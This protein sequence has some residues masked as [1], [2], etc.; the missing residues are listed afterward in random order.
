MNWFF[1]PIWYQSNFSF[2]GSNFQ[3]L[4]H[5]FLPFF[6]ASPLFLLLP[7]VSLPFH[8]LPLVSPPPFAF[9]LYLLNL[10][11]FFYLLLFS[12][13]LNKL[14]I[15]I[16]QSQKSPIIL[17][18][19]LSK[20]SPRNSMIMIFLSS[21]SSKLFLLNQ[22]KIR[23]LCGTIIEPKTQYPSFEAWKVKDSLI[24]SWLLNSMQPKIAWPFLFLFMTKEIFGCCY[25]YLFE[26]GRCC[27]NSSMKNIHATKQG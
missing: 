2:L 14:P 9:S 12:T 19:L 15:K 5:T 23:Y 4:N 7:L 25:T 27:S 13:W 1:Q 21:H 16:P 20:S 3:R 24:M 10:F 18:I 26:E 11:L 22:G 6:L 8:L 17:I